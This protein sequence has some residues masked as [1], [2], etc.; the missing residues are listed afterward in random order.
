MER[1][2][3]STLMRLI[4]DPAWNGVWLTTFSEY[5]TRDDFNCVFGLEK[6]HGETDFPELLDSPTPTVSQKIENI[7]ENAGIDLDRNY[8]ALKEALKAFE[9]LP[10]LNEKDLKTYAKLNNLV[11]GYGKAIS[12]SKPD[13]AL[14]IQQP[15]H[16]FSAPYDHS[17]IPEDDEEI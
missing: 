13:A 15:C 3:I 8:Y 17:A 4:K 7:V 11:N 2:R 12:L 14:E 6:E 9:K 16:A 5:L 10:N 1:L